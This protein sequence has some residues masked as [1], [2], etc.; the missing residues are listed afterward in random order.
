MSKL[1]PI[2]SLPSV[3]YLM[4][5]FDYDQVTGFLTWRI[6]PLSHFP[7]KGAGNR[8]NTCFAGKRVGW[9][10]VHGTRSR[11]YVKLDYVSYLVHRVA[12]AIYYGVWPVQFLD[13]INRN[14][15]DNR[16]NNLRQVTNGQNRANSKSSSVGRPKGV[17]WRKDNRRWCS[18]ITVGGKKR[19]LGYF[20][21]AIEAAVA[22]EQAAR[23]IYGE[24]LC[25]EARDGPTG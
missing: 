12:W 19:H 22:F 20:A 17:Y 11:L 5:C 18:N 24:F 10:N 23:E 13:H 6:R 8:W 21:T 15:F 3:E 2:K 16:I 14:P 25:V 1:R 9:A 4:E 7:N